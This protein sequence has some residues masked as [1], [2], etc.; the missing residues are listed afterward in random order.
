MPTPV[1]E[2]AGF[3]I[4][5]R[6]AGHAEPS[7]LLLRNRERGEWG[8]PKGHRDPSDT[9][10]LVTA[11]RE[12]AEE[13]GLSD[14]LV[15]SAFRRTVEYEVTTKRD[16]RA[17][18]RVTYLLARTEVTTV[19]LSAEHDAFVWAHPVEAI[20]MLKFDVLHKLLAA[21]VDFL[22]PSERSSHLL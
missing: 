21:A 22:V 16:H 13:T 5:R 18:K 8:F 17:T 14:V 15:H 3:L 20:Q 7:F 2:A 6:D 4:Y 11:C 12:L 1:V 10:L 19:N 9:D